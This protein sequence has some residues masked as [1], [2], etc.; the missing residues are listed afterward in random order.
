[1]RSQGVPDQFRELAELP[2]AQQQ[3]RLAKAIAEAN[4]YAG[5]ESSLE[6]G[7]SS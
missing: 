4:R 3:G 5:S 6:H 7:H 1:M 2:M